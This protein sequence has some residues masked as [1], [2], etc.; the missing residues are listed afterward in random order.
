[1]QQFAFEM[2]CTQCCAARE[3][4]ACILRLNQSVTRLG[5]TVIGCGLNHTVHGTP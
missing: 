1:M 4:L 2:S 3:P 5:L